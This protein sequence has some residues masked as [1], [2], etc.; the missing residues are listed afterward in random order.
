MSVVTIDPMQSSTTPSKPPS[1]FPLDQWYAAA[2]GWELKDR[3]IARTLLRHAVV[4]FRTPEGQVAALE[5]RCCHRALPL[6]QGTLDTGGIRCG[7]HGLLFNSQGQCIEIPGQTKIPGKARSD[8]ADVAL[9]SCGCTIVNHD[10]FNMLPSS[11]KLG[12]LA[13]LLSK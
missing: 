7:Y 12:C 5:D 13:K 3:P 11:A 2:L 1:T 4:L 9:A 6:S 8:G 10:F